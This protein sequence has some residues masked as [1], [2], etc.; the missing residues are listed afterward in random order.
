MVVGLRRP[1]AIARP[2]VV[3]KK[4]PF[5]GGGPWPR[6]GRG[7]SVRRQP[8]GPSRKKPSRARS[9]VARAKHYR[10]RGQRSMRARPGQGHYRPSIA[11]TIRLGAST[12][13]CLDS[14]A[15]RGRTQCKATMICG[16]RSSRLEAFPNRSHG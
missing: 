8:P 2:S 9:P 1:P 4:A 15:A 13:G 3:K 10:D 12:V 6:C 7:G 5:Q 11:S 16:L 14:G